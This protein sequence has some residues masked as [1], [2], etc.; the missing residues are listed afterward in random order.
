MPAYV[1]DSSKQPMVATGVVDAKFDWVETAGG[2]RAQSEVQTRDDVTGM[3]V[4]GVEVMYQQVQYGRTSSV[5][6][7]VTL[8]AYDRPYVTALGPVGFENLRVEVR[9][10]KNTGGL[11]EYW[12]ADSIAAPVPGS[13]RR[14]SSSS[15][16]S[17]SASSEAA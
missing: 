17:G 13:A 16:S 10:N 11:V 3:P 15:S 12:S 8:P 5:I 7:S 4:W 9:V 6:A 14:P 1:V 2:G